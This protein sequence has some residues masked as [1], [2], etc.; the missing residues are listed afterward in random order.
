MFTI[1]RTVEDVRS[2]V[3]VVAEDKTLP[4]IRMTNT[5]DEWKIVK[6]GDR[7]IV[8]G[9]K[10]EQ[11]ARRTDF[12]NEQAVQRLRDIMR[13]QGILHELV[14]QGIEPGNTIQLGSDESRRLEY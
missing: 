4:V 11:F 13:R 8:T 6:D 7:F 5:E 2:R 10:I 12:T 1:K 9:Q 14:R 3:E